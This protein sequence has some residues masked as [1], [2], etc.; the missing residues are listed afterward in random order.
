MK[1]LVP[2]CIPLKGGTPISET[3][4][5]VQEDW[6]E[7]LQVMSSP[8]SRNPPPTTQTPTYTARKAENV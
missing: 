2:L 6:I 4:S 1:K 8:G 3:T 7:I 5:S